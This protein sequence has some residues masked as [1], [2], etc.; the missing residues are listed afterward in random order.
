M[1]WYASISGHCGSQSSVKGQPRPP[2]SLS[3]NEWYC[4]ERM[5]GEEDMQSRPLTSTGTNHLKHMHDWPAKCYL[6]IQCRQYRGGVWDKRTARS[7]NSNLRYLRIILALNN[8]AIKEEHKP[9]TFSLY[10]EDTER[11]IE[12]VGVR[13]KVMFY[14]LITIPKTTIKQTWL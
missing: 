7:R 11:W 3:S 12:E 4:L 14:V 1:Q 8:A 5:R 10:E 13:L 2:V 6:A 9:R